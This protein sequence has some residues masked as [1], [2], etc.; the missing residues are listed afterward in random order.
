MHPRRHTSVVRKHGKLLIALA[1]LAVV[2]AAIAVAAHD[3]EPHYHGMSLS[4]WF[5]ASFSHSA[6]P[7]DMN[8][9]H[10]VREI[11]TNA[12]PWFLK[13]IRY[14]PT[15]W[16]KT[17]RSRLPKSFLNTD[18]GSFISGESAEQKVLYG[19]LGFC[20]LGTNAAPA[21]SA[22]SSIMRDTA[23]PQ[24]AR[25][26]IAAL[27]CIGAPAFPDLYSAF[28]DTNCPNRNEITV[29]VVGF[30]LDYLG[31]HAALTVIQTA[32]QD[33]DPAVRNAVMIVLESSDAVLTNAPAK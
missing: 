19:T 22:L 11:G 21:V 25:F 10:A 24:A 6:T 17:A 3:K 13:W 20:F 9:E 31:P 2:A 4:E 18:F 27:A 23:H 12:I 33:P 28:A 7:D 14:E 30:A 15:A 1:C 26:S 8:P 16:Q 32:L 5:Q 29:Y